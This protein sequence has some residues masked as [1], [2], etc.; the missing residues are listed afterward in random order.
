MDEIEKIIA[1]QKRDSAGIV[2]Y[3]AGGVAKQL[4]RY[5]KLIGRESSVRCFVV[6]SR[7]ACS[8]LTDGIPVRSVHDARN[9]L[10]KHKVIIAT[11]PRHFCAIS[12][13]LE[14]Y[15]IKNYVKLTQGSQNAIFKKYAK[16]VYENAAIQ[17][18]ELL[19]DPNDDGYMCLVSREYGNT[20]LKNPISVRHYQVSPSA[21]VPENAE[22]VRKLQSF[23]FHDDYEKMFGPYRHIA[24]LRGKRGPNADESPLTV[25]MVTSHLNLAAIEESAFDSAANIIP[26][27]AGA[28]LTDRTVCELKDN[29][30]DN[31]SRLNGNLSEMSAMYWIWKNAGLPGYVGLCHYRR[32]FLLDTVN[33]A[34]L[35]QEGVDVILPVPRLVLPDIAE[36]FIRSGFFHREDLD[37]TLSI[38][39][40]KYPDYTRTAAEFLQGIL[41]Y[42]CNMLIAAKDVFCE[43]CE[44]VFSVL[45]EQYEARIES[46]KQCVPRDLGYIA[47][48]LT[49]IYFIHN[50][51]SLNIYLADIRLYS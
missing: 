2:I 29:A 9:D 40:R 48:L 50:K 37:H 25:Y 28:A 31:I 49:S 27:Q 32:H 20:A 11:M 39:Q 34:C 23:R 5:M 18:Y 7:E 51:E 19:E 33:A 14:R 22:S 35:S 13:T 46:G 4:Y 44:F 17:D 47:E 21:G 30:G 16:A 10:L 36:S 1:A 8:V 24:G 15:G 6:T 26:I 12:K 42:P 3:G 45:T 43:Y 38:V 41:F